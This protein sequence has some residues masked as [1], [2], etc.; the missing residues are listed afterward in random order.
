MATLDLSQLQQAID[1]GNP[2]AVNFGAFVASAPSLWQWTA[3]SG[4]FV[5][6][7]GSGMTF[8]G[9]HA[10]SGTV[11][12]IGF[13][14]GNNGPTVTEIQI[15]GFSIAATLLDNSALSFWRV[16]EGNDTITGATA[17]ATPG[18]ADMVTLFGDNIAVRSGVI[19]G[20]D[21]VIGSGTA[22][23]VI[24]GDVVDV[25]S[26]APGA[27][28]ANYTGG[29]DTINCALS[30]LRQ[31]IYGD[32][33]TVHASGR[34]AGGNDV[35][36]FTDAG[37]GSALYGDAQTV[38]GV[39]GDLAVFIGGND[40]I[41]A[42][43]SVT[44]FL[45]IEGD[46]G[47]AG[48]F[49]TIRGGNDTLIGGAGRDTIVGDVH[50]QTGDIICG[51]DR[52]DGGAGDD[53]LVGDVHNAGDGRIICGNDIIRGG[54]GADGIIGDA[55]NLSSGTVQV[56]GDDRLFGDAGNDF[57]IGRTGNDILVGG[58]GADSLD[59]GDGID[60]ASYA[61]ALAGVRADLQAPGTNTG[62]ALGD[63][64]I[65]IEVLVGSGFSDT[66]HGDAGNESIAG[67]RGDDGLSG[68]SGNDKLFGGLGSDRMAGGAGR[69]AFVFDSALNSITNH[70]TIV[71]FVAADDTVRLDHRIFTALGQTSGT[72]AA[73]TFF[74]SATGLAH[75]ASDRI[76]YNTSTG[77]LSYD[78][79][80]IGAGAAVR[81][82]QLTGAPAIT[83]ADFLVI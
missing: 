18:L 71:D 80:G 47:N 13:D 53:N 31:E 46:I 6:I 5:D 44:D 60:T 79:D 63:S 19:K 74:A 83:N 78:A 30:T 15:F 66:L 49:A 22:R 1:L 54:D 20:G 12:A 75:D 28:A 61:T 77:I 50:N 7:V 64:Y 25:G 56:G 2:D 24:Y 51:N 81:F 21:D 27:P 62:D 45:L 36:N 17:T 16:M 68:R 33:R 58:E 8:S 26:D 42:H 59:G 52:I 14:V 10:T 43:L 65:S 57:I 69:D 3:P 9:G 70:D 39:A 4:N 11:S 82:A 48:Q 37:F 23:T 55:A 67:A 41:N 38:N 73:A 29:A 76:V 34:L 32:A 72:L 35:I 40:T